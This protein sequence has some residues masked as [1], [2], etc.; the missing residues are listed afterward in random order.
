MILD[1]LYNC[2]FFTINTIINKKPNV[3]VF[4]S[5]ACLNTELGIILFMITVFIQ[6]T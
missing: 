1:L 3:N 5:N 2:T 6:K 4:V